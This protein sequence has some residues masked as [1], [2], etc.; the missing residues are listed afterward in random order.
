MIYC[1]CLNF[2]SK[3]DVI[4]L[5]FLKDQPSQ[6]NFRRCILSLDLII[7]FFQSNNNQL[8]NFLFLLIKGVLLC[9]FEVV[10]GLQGINDF[11]HVLCE[12]EGEERGEFI[13]GYL[14]GLDENLG[15]EDDLLT[16]MEECIKSWVLI[17]FMILR[18]RRTIGDISCLRSQRTCLSIPKI[19]GV[20]SLKTSVLA[21]LRLHVVLHGVLPLEFMMLEVVLVVDVVLGVHPLEGVHVG[22][23]EEMGILLLQII[24]NVVS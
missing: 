16:T 24:L 3:L 15:E 6:I 17:V 10:F 5:I 12:E 11:L 21:A 4:L 22:V 20:R 18:T 9:H 2:T 19:L 23:V 8:Q 14:E 7:H 1:C 13:L